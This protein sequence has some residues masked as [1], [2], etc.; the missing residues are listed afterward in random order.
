MSTILLDPVATTNSR[1]FVPQLGTLAGWELLSLANAV[2][3]KELT[4]YEW[5]AVTSCYE[6][7]TE[8]IATSD[9]HEDGYTVLRPILIEIERIGDTDFTASFKEANIAI[10]GLDRQDA[11]QALVAEILDTFDALTEEENNL[12]PDAATQLQTLRAYIVKA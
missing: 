6:P 2:S 11:Y 5:Q 8:S 1:P 3:P 7:K 9:L 4:S 12:G 10:G